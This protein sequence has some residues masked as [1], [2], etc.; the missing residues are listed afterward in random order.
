VDA[1]DEPGVSMELLESFLEKLESRSELTPFS[2]RERESLEQL[3]AA[4]L[5]G[6]EIPVSAEFL[7]D[8]SL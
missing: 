8:F 6:G 1:K 4:V 3:A 2:P 7:E 5:S